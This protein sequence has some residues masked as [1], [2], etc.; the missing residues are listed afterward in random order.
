MLHKNVSEISTF[1]QPK[2]GK[3][4]ESKGEGE[5]GKKKGKKEKEDKKKKDKRGTQRGTHVEGNTKS[6]AEDQA[7][8]SAARKTNVPEPTEIG[9]RASKKPADKKKKKKK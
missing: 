1:L 5:E 3:G 6:D 9:A 2:P 7:R 4:A 8:P